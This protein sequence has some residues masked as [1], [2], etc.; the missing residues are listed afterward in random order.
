MEKYD[1]LIK[2]NNLST[3]SDIKKDIWQMI[4][5][6]SFK[7]RP[8]A[9]LPISSKAAD[10]ATEVGLKQAE[11]EGSIRS[12]DW[13]HEN[14]K[15]MD[16]IKPGK[17]TIPQAGRGAFATR[18]IPAGDIV[19]PAP[20]IHIPNKDN[21]LMYGKTM[22]PSDDH[23]ESTT[24]I[25]NGTD[26]VGKQLLLNYCFGHREST[27]LLC[28]YSGGAPHINHNHQSPNAKIVW[29]EDATHSMIHD[30]T[31]L[32]QSVSYID[33]NYY[34]PGLE[35]DYVATRDIQPDEEVSGMNKTGQIYLKHIYLNFV[36][37]TF[38][39]IWNVIRYSLIMVMNGRKP[40]R[41]ILK[42][43]TQKIMLMNIKMLLH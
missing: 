14:G 6:S 34:S 12:L 3:K 32:S 1:K 9:A 5:Q 30:S 23:D 29:P 20:L 18:F 10:R 35:F 36:P 39:Y 26:I 2:S 7:S 17:S 19:T 43:G 22:S 13:L 27:L 41:N 11:L 16:N 40:G 8:L 33:E 15:C 38:L 31:W 4:L 24:K 28:P 25:R 37:C 42:I 21:L